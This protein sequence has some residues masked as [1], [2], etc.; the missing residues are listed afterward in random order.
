MCAKGGPTLF[1]SD[2]NTEIAG[3][4]KK[5]YESYDKFVSAFSNRAKGHFGSGWI[6]L[7]V[8]N[9]GDLVITDGH[10]AFNPITDGLLPILVIDVWEHAYYVDQR[11]NRGK[12][13]ECFIGLIN[14][15]NV[16]KAYKDALKVCK[17]AAAK[18]KN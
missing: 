2:S 12:Y 1:K 14:W 5:K 18:A 11:N 10:D 8:N 7:S 15:D 17:D 9:K 16:N 13:V 4:I 3:A 6:W